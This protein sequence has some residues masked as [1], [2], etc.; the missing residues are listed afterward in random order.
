MSRCTCGSSCSH[1]AAWDA[2]VGGPGG[3]LMPLAKTS[4]TTDH[5]IL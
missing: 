5:C 3:V 2:L 4:S 1:T